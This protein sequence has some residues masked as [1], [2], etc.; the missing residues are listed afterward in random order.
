MFGFEDLK[1]FCV[2]FGMLVK[3]IL[4]VDKLVDENMFIILLLI[5]LVLD[6]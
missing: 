4:V 1:G 6:N 5:V 3:V 2:M